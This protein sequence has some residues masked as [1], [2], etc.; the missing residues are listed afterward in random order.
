MKKYDTIQIISPFPCSTNIKYSFCTNSHT[1]GLTLLPAEYHPEAEKWKLFSRY[2][3]KSPPTDCSGALREVH[4]HGSILLSRDR[5]LNLARMAS[6]LERWV[7]K[8]EWFAVPVDGQNVCIIILAS[9]LL[10]S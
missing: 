4:F 6:E 3:D 10:I 9:L 5:I 7:C 2:N 8:V 1:H